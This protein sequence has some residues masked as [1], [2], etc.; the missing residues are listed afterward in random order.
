MQIAQWNLTKCWWSWKN[1]NIL[2]LQ[3]MFYLPLPIQEAYR[4][5]QNIPI[6]YSRSKPWQV[7]FLFIFNTLILLRSEAQYYSKAPS[8]GLPGGSIPTSW[9]NRPR[10]TPF[11]KIL[12]KIYIY[13][14]YWAN[15]WNFP[16]GY[17]DCKQKDLK[18][19]T[20]SKNNEG[21]SIPPT[22]K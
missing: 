2:R 19:I 13:N 22:D 17:L 12:L 4:G 10:I 14:P 11:N 6:Y 8:N 20:A 3:K 1:N 18:P 7:M 21:F 9:K 15:Q 5:E 16:Y